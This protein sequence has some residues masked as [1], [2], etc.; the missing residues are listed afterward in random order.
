[1]GGERDP[2]FLQPLFGLPRPLPRCRRAH[3]VAGR[4]PPMFRTSTG[5]MYEGQRPSSRSNIDRSDQTN[6][7]ALGSPVGRRNLP[8]RAAVTSP[9]RA[10][11]AAT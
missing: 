8:R 11:S 3:L 6:P 10:F 2:V 7:L 9:W 1:M 5:R 4:E